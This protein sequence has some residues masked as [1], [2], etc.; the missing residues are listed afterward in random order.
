MA[1]DQGVIYNVDFKKKLTSF[2]PPLKIRLNE[3]DI[4]SLAHQVFLKFETVP[5]FSQDYYLI[6]IFK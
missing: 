6:K 5:N 2:G 4:M 3:V 1:N